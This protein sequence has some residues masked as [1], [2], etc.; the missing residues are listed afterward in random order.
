MVLKQPYLEDESQN[1]MSPREEKSPIRN[2]KKNSMS[3]DDFNYQSDGSNKGNI[4]LKK[5]LTPISNILKEF[6]LK[7]FH[8]FFMNLDLVAIRL[9]I[10]S[11]MERTRR[12]WKHL[13]FYGIGTRNL[14]SRTLMELLLSPMLWDN[15]HQYV[16]QIGLILM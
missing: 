2:L 8:V 14:L 1:N 9:D 16:G 11:W 4:V 3:G 5:S 15:W 12:A 10:H 7:F 6:N 13:C